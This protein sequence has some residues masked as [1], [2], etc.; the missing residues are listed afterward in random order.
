MRIL[1]TG[2]AGYIGSMLANR[3][4]REGG[5]QIT[6]IDLLQQPE[7]VPQNKNL[8]WIKQDLAQNNW[9]VETLKTGPIDAVVHLAFKIRS[10]Y[11]KTEETKE[12]NLAACRNVFEFVFK[13]KIPLLIYSSSVA[14]YGAKKENIG[15]LLKEN[16]PL[17]ENLSPYGHQ[18]RLVEEMLQVL[19]AKTKPATHTVILRLN[20]VTGP[21][22]QGMKSKF[23]LIT[24]LKKLLPFVIETNPAWAR[25]FVHEND[26][27]EVIVKLLQ[28]RPQKGAFDIY[29]IAPPSFLTAKDMARVLGKKLLRVPQRLIRPAFWLAWHLTRGRMPTHPDSSNGLIYPINVDGSKIK[30]VGFNYGFG[31]E[32]AFLGKTNPVK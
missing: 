4:L 7:R 24:F 17:Q 2:V 13:N 27:E 8:L 14:A 9:Q 23:G 21:I 30:E 5:H 28:R 25:Q 15:R 26:V 3:L 1:I 19:I 31:P 29:N 6:A 20:S 12:E 10:P 16:D 22:G 11:R 18:K 32:D